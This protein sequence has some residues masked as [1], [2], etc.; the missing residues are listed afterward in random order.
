VIE[1]VYGETMKRLTEE[2]KNQFLT[3]LISLIQIPSVL[4]EYQPGS[5][6][7]FGQPIQEALEQMLSIGQRDGFH[8][9]SVD[10]YAGVIEVGSG[11]EVGILGHLDI[12][13][14][15][16][17]WSVGPFSGEIRDGKLYGRGVNDD[18][19]PTMAAY[20]AMKW[21]KESGIPLKK[22]I[23]L[24]LGTDEE[25]GMRC[26]QHYLTKHKPSSMAFAPDAVFPLIYAEKGIHSCEVT[27]AETSILAFESGQRLNMVPELAKAKLTKNVTKEFRSYLESNHVSGEIKDDWLIV[28]GKG[29][30]AM[31]PDEGINAATLL[32][33]FLVQIVDSPFTRLLSTMDTTGNAFGIDYVSSEMG[34][35]T[36]NVG[37]V[38]VKDGQFSIKINSRIPKGYPFMSEYETA[39][40][41]FGTYKELNDVPV[42]YVSQDSTLVQTLLKA[43]QSVTGD[44]SSR[45]ITIGGGTYARMVPNAVAFG[46]M[47][48]GREDVA[49]RVDEYMVIEDLYTAIEIYIQALLDLAT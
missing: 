47:L 21:I 31:Q 33:R 32:G 45:P 13:P 22:R 12:V 49:H 29:A 19:G 34:P 28:H 3:D 9:F 5:N 48:P 25:S 8:T 7:P 11:D 27:G 2:V 42:H 37:L 4:N 23:R 41:Q 18:K 26:I 35:I 1:Y 30:H 24:I 17:G 40:S 15:Q 14:V 38:H 43:Y 46:A 39:L 16:D 36:F 10:D 44:M 6:P 20:Y